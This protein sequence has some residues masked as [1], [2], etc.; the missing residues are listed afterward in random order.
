MVC[1]RFLSLSSRA[2]SR[3]EP[4]Q[5]LDTLEWLDL[6]L[7][8][9]VSHVSLPSPQWVIFTTNEKET[10]RASETTARLRLLFEPPSA[11]YGPHR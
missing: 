5:T 4:D 3:T 10:L 1:D 7:L 2:L 6:M 8:P 9:E 11:N